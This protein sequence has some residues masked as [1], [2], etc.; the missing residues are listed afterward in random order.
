MTQKEENRLSNEQI[1]CKGEG[2]VFVCVLC[3][4]SELSLLASV[5]EVIVPGAEVVIVPRGKLE[6]QAIEGGRHGVQK[7]VHCPIHAIQG[8]G[9]VGASCVALEVPH[10]GVGHTHIQGDHGA[11]CLGPVGGHP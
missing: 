10:A 7:R 5:G 6:D 11:G 8:A 2:I 3:C 1:T 9:G 4:H